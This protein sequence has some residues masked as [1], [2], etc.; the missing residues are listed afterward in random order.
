MQRLTE[1]LGNIKGNY[2]LK[3]TTY[4]KHHVGRRRQLIVLIYFCI[5]NLI[6]HSNLGIA[7]STA[8]ILAEQ[9]TF[10]QVSFEITRDNLDGFSKT[11]LNF[12]KE[13]VHLT[14]ME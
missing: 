3:I 9:L 6:Y 4:R 13:I 2:L 11:M 14:S 8:T 5:N 12:Q 10:E 1:N 7:I